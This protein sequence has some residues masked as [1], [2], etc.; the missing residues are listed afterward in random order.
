MSPTNAKRRHRSLVDYEVQGRLLRKISL[1]WATL[2]VANTHT[3]APD[4]IGIFGEPIA[5]NFLSPASL[6]DRFFTLM[7]FLHIAVPLILRDPLSLNL[8]T[9]A[10]ALAQVTGVTVIPNDG[11]Q[12]QYRSRGY[13][14]SVMNDG[15]PGSRTTS[16]MPG[17]VA[18]MTRARSWLARISRRSIVSLS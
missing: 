8:A 1:Q 6:D 10:E 7:L 13:A 16:R 3:P 18:A 15:I 5:R 2:F 11:I 9:V 14:L 4:A 17:S 12:S